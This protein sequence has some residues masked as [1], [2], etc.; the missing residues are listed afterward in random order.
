[1]YTPLYLLRVIVRVDSGRILTLKVQV[2]QRLSE[3]LIV[4][5]F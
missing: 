4:N 1:M 5:S 3:S 2:M